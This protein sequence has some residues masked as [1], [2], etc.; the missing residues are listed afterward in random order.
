M[1]NLTHFGLTRVAFDAF[2]RTHAELDSFLDLLEVSVRLAQG[3]KQ[4]FRRGLLIQDVEQIV[5][6]RVAWAERFLGTTGCHWTPYSRLD[7]R[8]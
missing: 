1:S 7:F 8:L 5:A 4:S 6:F 2:E 3:G